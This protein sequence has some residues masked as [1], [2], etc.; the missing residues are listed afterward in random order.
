M[1]VYK[2]KTEVIELEFQVKK[3]P[4]NNPALVWKR[5]SN[6]SSLCQALF[7]SPISLDLKGVSSLEVSY[8]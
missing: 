4:P 5:F 6:S 3:L 2:S 1:K 7:I 8:C